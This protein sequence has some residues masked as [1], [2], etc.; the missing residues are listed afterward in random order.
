MRLSNLLLFGFFFCAACDEDEPFD[1]SFLHHDWKVVSA[2]NASNVT[3]KAVR[4]YILAFSPTGTAW[5]TDRNDCY[6]DYILEPDRISINVEGCSERCCDTGI[7]AE[8]NSL[9]M[10]SSSYHMEGD[11]LIL[12]GEGSVK[13]ARPLVNCEGTA[14]H[15]ILIY[16]N[17][18]I[19]YG[20]GSPVALTS[21]RLVRVSDGALIYSYDLSSQPAG[22]G[23]SLISNTKEKDFRDGAVLVRYEGFIGDDLVVEREFSFKSTCCDVEVV[24][25]LDIVI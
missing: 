19:K 9:I 16:T 6:G 25:D 4:G 7:A 17:I 18:S 22:P 11:T 10:S 20:D 24:G 1:Q 3:F 8:L 13:L 12:T 14:C 5:N 23:Y 21:A 15:R 2:T